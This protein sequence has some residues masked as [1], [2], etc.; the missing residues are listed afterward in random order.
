MLVLGLAAAVPAE[1]ASAAA[2]PSIVLVVTDDQRWDTLW[3][4]PNVR[5]LLARRGVR[6]ENAF[7]TNPL[8]CPSRTALLTGGYS[9]DTGVYTNVLPHGGF[10]AFDDSSTLATWLQEAGY[11]TAYLGKYLN[12]YEWPYVPPGWDR[13]LAYAGAAT[14]F[15]YVL[16][17]DGALVSR[18]RD[19]EDYSTD[20]FAAEAVSFIEST[21]GPLFLHLAPLAPHADVAWR[22]EIGWRPIP[23]P[24]DAGSFDRLEPWRPAAF[25]ERDV[26]DKPPWI[27][28]RSLTGREVSRIDSFRRRQLQSL[29]AVDLAVA[30]V[31]AALERTGRLENAVIVFTSDNGFSLG[32]HRWIS[33]WVPYEESIR[34]PL[35]IRHDPLTEEARRDDRLVVNVDLAQTLAELAG[36]A[37]PGAKGRSLVPLL[38]GE[39][40]DWR[41]NFVLEGKSNAIPAY[42]GIRSE[43]FMYAQYRGGTEE[44]YD[45]GADPQQLENLA[46]RPELR[47]RR[48]EFRK[49]VREICAPPTPGLR[50]RSPCLVTGSS[51]ADRLSGTRWYD[52]ACGRAGDD[53]IEA[54]SGRDDVLGGTGNDSIFGGAGGDTLMGGAGTDRV[55]GGAGPDHISTVDGERDRVVCGPGRDVA[56]ADPEDVLAGCERTA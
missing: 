56:L 46:R 26:G 49:R 42:C 19:P 2:P 32:E 33:K 44:L 37:A 55:H 53:R 51:S 24:R 9:H 16:N 29:Q 43:R 31:V 36:V 1:S 28:K 18:G 14:Y 22:A 34:V 3:A 41:R 52:L 8:C 4:M 7:V 38:A 47:S 11:Q 5:G 48:V 39:S 54:R 21:R 27:K 6:F 35:V 40:T 12:G 50:L 23:A 30:N 20:V 10:Y 45:L 25:D 13:W 15:D 17:D